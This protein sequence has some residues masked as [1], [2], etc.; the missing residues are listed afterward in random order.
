MAETEKFSEVTKVTTLDSGASI[1]LF[2]ANGGITGITATNFKKEVLNGSAVSDVDYV[3]GQTS[4][5]EQVKISKADLASVVGGLNDVFIMYHRKKDSYP[6]ASTL[7]SWPSL[8]TS[9][10]VADGVLV[11]DGDKHLII[12]PT[13]SACKWAS[14]SVSGGGTTTTDRL[15][16]IND[17]S[18]QANTASQVTHAECS[19]ESYAP[20]FCNTYSN[21]GLAAGK[22]WLPSIGELMFIFAH[23][24]EIN[25]ALS[26]VSGAKQVSGNDYWSSTEASNANAWYILFNT[27]Y[28]TRGST[29]VNGL[30]S[31]RPVSAFI[32]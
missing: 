23:R 16:A 4:S 2:D 3:I 7:A 15:T 10:E 12:A 17:W 19:D 11:V 20:G 29:K 24:A 31:V 28:I 22:W 25:Y 13:E 32:A 6:L 5:G 27:C 30:C 14:A 9:G 26:L 1:P 21:G 18:G 8:Q